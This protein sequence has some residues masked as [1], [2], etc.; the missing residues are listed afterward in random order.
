MLGKI[1][2]FYEDEV[3]ASIQSLTS[4]VEPIMMLGVGLMVGI[5]IISHVP[6]DVQAADADQV[7]R[8]T[9]RRGFGPP[10]G[11]EGRGNH[12][13]G[14]V[15]DAAQAAASG[16]FL[17]VGIWLLLF[18]LLLPAAVVGYAIG[19]DDEEAAR[20]VT[21]GE[22]GKP[23][24]KPAAIEAAPAFSA[25][26][27]TAE[28]TDRWITN[29]GSSRTS[30]TRPWTRSTPTTWRSSRVSGMTSLKGSGTAA[31]Y[32]AEAQPIVYEGTMYVPTGADDVFAVDVDTGK[33]LWE[34]NAHLEQT[35][36]SVCCGWLS[37]GVALGD[38]KVY[39]GQLD[40]KLVALD[41]KTGKVAWTTAVGR[42]QDGFTLTHAPL[43]YDGMVIVGGSGGEFSLR[44]RVDRLRR[45]HGQAEVALLDDPRPRR[46]RPRHVAPGQRLVEDRRRAGLADPGG[47][48]RARPALLLDRQCRPRPEREQA[49]GRQP[50]HGLDRRGRREDRKIPLALPAGP[51]RHLGL[52]RPEPR[53]PVRRR[54]EEGPRP[55]VEDRLALPPRPGDGQAAPADP[56]E[57]CAAA[58]V[59]EDGQDAAHPELS[60]FH[61]ARGDG[62]ARSGR[63]QLK[64][65]N[66]P[67]KDVPVERAEQVY[68]PFDDKAITVV[69]PGPQGGTN[70]QP[71]SYSPETEMFY[72]CAQ[73]AFSGLVLLEQERAAGQAGRPWPTS[74]APSSPPGS[75]TT[76]AT[77][78]RSTPTRVRSSGRS[79]GRSRATR[80]RPR[81]GAGSSSSAGTAATSR[82]TTPRTASASGASR[83]GPAPTR[84]RRRSS[85]TAPRRSRLLAGGNALAATPHGDNLWLF[86]LNGTMEQLKGVGEAAEGVG[87]AGE[88][89]TEP[90]VATA[91]RRRARPSGRTT[92]PAVMGSRA[93]AETAA[94]I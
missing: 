19:N 41:Q 61:P 64:K 25:E 79:A 24:V 12:A 38:G 4:I 13:T 17:D 42:W 86:A 70:W 26:D 47:R 62:G 76:P 46:D 39:L 21:V 18:V 57:A 15:D 8:A 16:W 84:R 55:S 90:T 32:S 29:G 44:G 69:V 9:A 74:A 91:T 92:A 37:R 67:L 1:A 35:I 87:H 80:A 48:S 68:T 30:A 94:P 66:K 7:A 78:P 31:K 60:A 89:P 73:A 22:D 23:I 34:Y 72:V 3:D 36:S 5:V 6:A 51:S 2:D 85:T 20:T 58:R 83:P 43:Y 14:G 93:R 27:L 54:R 50:V 28:P 49:R 88:T 10:I 75:A 40:G 59:T 65:A 11:G 63:Q 56:R 52:R 53:R 71:T 45:D 82:R 77:S 33:I 81:R